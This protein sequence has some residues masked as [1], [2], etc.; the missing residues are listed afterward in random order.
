MTAINITSESKILGETKWQS[1]LIVA[2]A[3]T[4]QV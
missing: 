2:Q 4:L 1:E 3:I